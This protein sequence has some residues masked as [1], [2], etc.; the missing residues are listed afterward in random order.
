MVSE[1]QQVSTQVIKYNPQLDGLRFFA[2]L[3][4]VTY[5]WMPYVSELKISYFFGGFINFFFVLSSYLITKIL[6][7]AKEKSVSKGISKYKVMSVFLLRR[8]IRIFPA[9]YFFLLVVALM[10]VIGI[11]VRKNADMYFSYLINYQMFHD[12]I[13]SPVT[14]HIWTLAVE[15]QFYFIWPFVILFVPYRYLLR[16]FLLMLICSVVLRLFTYQPFE[17]IPQVIL[18]HYCFDPFAIGG[19]LAYKYTLPVEKRGAISKGFNI[20]LYVAIPLVLMIV[21]LQSFYFSFVVGGL[22]FSIISMKLIEGAI[23]GYKASFGRFLQHR[24]VLFIGKI[25]YG[26]YLYHLLVPIVFWKLFDKF[27]DSL[28]L[29]FPSFFKNNEKGI[30]IFFKIIVSPVSCFIIYAICTLLVAIL[31]WNLIEKPFY[32]LKTAISSR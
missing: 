13:W 4:V 6:F 5:H 30:E 22:V 20:A 16:T 10:P 19:L 12:Q 24:I 29:H 8:V 21:L 18:T 7:F 9:Y 28:E 14:S 31:S 32:R 23:L 1:S 11:E 17:T 15:E 2:V 3:A 26:I 25:S 27:Y